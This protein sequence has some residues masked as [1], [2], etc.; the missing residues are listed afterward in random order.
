MY[1]ID[2]CAN[3]PESLQLYREFCLAG[4]PGGVV[5]NSLLQRCY[6]GQLLVRIALNGVLLVSWGTMG[7]FIDRDSRQ[8]KTRGKRVAFVHTI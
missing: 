4:R 3:T 8:N 2:N 7:I 5:F 1:K 6:S